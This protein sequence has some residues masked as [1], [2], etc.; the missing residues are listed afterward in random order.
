MLS[1]TTSCHINPILLS[2]SV[3]HLHVEFASLVVAVEEYLQMYSSEDPSA[4][5]PGSYDEELHAQVTKMF[6]EAAKVCS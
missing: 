1:I 3:L 5:L 4:M 6:R 2:L